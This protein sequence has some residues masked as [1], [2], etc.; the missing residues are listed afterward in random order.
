M[1]LSPFD[2]FCLDGRVVMITGASSGLGA[3]FAVLLARVGGRIA[4]AARRTDKLLPLVEKITQAGGEARAL[5][6]DVTDSESVHACF[7]A[8]ANWG[9]DRKS[10]HPSPDI[11]PAATLKTRILRAQPRPL[12]FTWS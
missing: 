10:N 11:V 6:L 3:H 7:D 12:G 1:S 8:L 5:A 4:L 9:R 2:R